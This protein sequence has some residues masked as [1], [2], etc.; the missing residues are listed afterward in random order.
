MQQNQLHASERPNILILHTDQQ[1]F[2]TI[3]ALGADHMHT[4]NIDRLVKQGTAFRHAYSST[5]VCQP[6][7]HDLLTGVSGRRHGYFTNRPGPIADYCLATIPRLLTEAGYQTAAVGKMHFHPPREHHGFAHM[8]LMEELPSC[9]EDDAYLEYLKEQGYQDVRCEHGVRP[10]FYHTPQASR[11]PEEHHGSAWVAT[12]TIELLEEERD[13]PLFIWSSWVG[14]HPPYYVPEKYFDLYRD[15][16]LPTP[17]PPTGDTARQAPVSPEN[18]EP[19]DLRMRMIQEA[20]YAAITLIDTHIGRILD[21]LEQSGRADN[22]IVIFTTD[23]GEML[24]DLGGYQ[25]HIPYEGSAHIPLIARGPGF[26]EG[27][28]C[29]TAATTWDTAATIIEAAGLTVPDD[30][31]LVGTSLRTLVSVDGGRADAGCFDEED[32]DDS[33]I[34]VYH[35][36]LNAGRYVAAVNGRFKLIHWYNGGQEELYDLETDPWEQQNLLL[37]TSTFSGDSTEIDLRGIAAALRMACI[38]FERTHGVAENVSGGD[39]VD[40]DYRE[41]P[42]HACS[43]YPEWSSRQPPPWTNGY[44]PEDLTLIAGEM[45]DCLE[46][47]AAYICTETE[48]REKAVAEWEKIGGDPAVYHQLF[49]EADAKQT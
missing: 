2:D 5:P 35:H 38:E 24:G 13:R 19:G 33:R 26:P 14:P 15:R 28:C 27:A 10:L 29:G 12:K 23:H 4:P 18:P 34:V 42:R 41:P 31:G 43:L 3:A 48:W 21:A 20:Y 39:F 1:R 11:V 16:P 40:R 49:S 8:F 45:R 9:R 32:P 25:K 30:H 6:A 44:S 17:C 46:S 22:T 36:G 37:D 7:R 47:P